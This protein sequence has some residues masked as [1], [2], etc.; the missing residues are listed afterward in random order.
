M[1]EAMRDNFLFYRSFM[2]ALEGLDDQTYRRLVEAA[3]HYALDGEEPELTGLERS[4]FVSWKANIDRSNQNRDN[5]KT[6][7]R[8]KKPVVTECETSGFE[9]ENQW[10]DTPETN[11]KE[12]EKVKEKVKEKEKTTDTETETDTETVTD[13]QHTKARARFTP[14]TV[15][16]VREYCQERDNH[17]DP[18]EFVDFYSS[19]GWHVGRD[20]MTDWKASVRTWEKR[21]REERAR[22]GTSVAERVSIVDS[23]LDRRAT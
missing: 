20:S 13:K 23:W 19:K 18:E 5:G 21:K 17:V 9:D 12:K 16:E 1:G 2:E 15:E 8:P 7:G 6:G 4:V 11:L 14:P 22:S 10:L 3:L